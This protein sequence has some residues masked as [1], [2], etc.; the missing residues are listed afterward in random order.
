MPPRKYEGDF[1]ERKRQAAMAWKNK[2]PEHARDL[3]NVAA[4]KRK[5]TDP[6]CVYFKWLECRARTQR[7]DKYVGF[8]LTLEYVRQLMAPMICT[9]TGHT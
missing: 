1:A 2:D 6:V 7:K 8:H 5:Q 4:K 9:Q 3:F